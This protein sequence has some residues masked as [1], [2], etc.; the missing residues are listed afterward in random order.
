MELLDG[1]DLATHLDKHGTMSPKDVADKAAA[2]AKDMTVLDGAERRALAYELSRAGFDGFILCGSSDS[3]TPDK[4]ILS[5]ARALLRDL[6]QLDWE[7][8]H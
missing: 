6:D 3:P 1:H 4:S 7:S 5:T 8:S 2:N